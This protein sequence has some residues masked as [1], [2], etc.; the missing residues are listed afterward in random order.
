MSPT[1]FRGLYL[2]QVF[3]EFQDTKN[4]T[5]LKLLPDS[6]EALQAVQELTMIWEKDTIANQPAPPS[7]IPKDNITKP[8]PKPIVE[9]SDD[10]DLEPF[11]LPTKNK[12]LVLPRY[13]REC[14]EYL[15]STDKLE[16]IEAGLV[17]VSGI[18]MASSA[19]DVKA[20]CKDVCSILFF[21]RNEFELPQF[22]EQRSEGLVTCLVLD[23]LQCSG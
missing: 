16:K 7:P 19:L 11:E 18:L 22:T 9:D 5:P 1:R 10:E 6:T 21:L 4:E 17:S 15:Q 23:P 8:V 13:L 20:L 2:L 14:I 12:T 3:S